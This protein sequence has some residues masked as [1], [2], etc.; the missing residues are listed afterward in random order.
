MRLYLPLSHCK[1]TFKAKQH[2]SNHV[3]SH[4]QERY[5]CNM[6]F[7]SYARN[8][9]LINHKKVVHFGQ[10]LFTCSFEGCNKFFIS[11]FN[12]KVHMRIH[13]GEKPYSC[14]FCTLKF[15][16]IGNRNDH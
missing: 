9:D 11:G 7:K 14:K 10:D 15:R 12:L 8:P 4:N 16:S 6:C 1:K 2:L 5:S 3:R 13:S